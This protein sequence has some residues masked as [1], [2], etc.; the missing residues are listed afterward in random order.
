MPPFLQLRRVSKRYGG[1]RALDG[2][3]FALSGGETHGLIGENGSG[4][5]TLIKI[6]SGAERPEPGAELLVVD[7]PAPFPTPAGAARLGVQVIPQDLALFPNLT[8]AENIA[9]PGDL[10]RPLLAPLP[11]RRSA[12]AAQNALD[13][14]G[15]ALPLSA[16]VED[17]PVAER[18]LVAICRAIAAEARL[19][20]MDEPTAA[21]TAD[22]VRRLVAIIATLKARGVAVL[23]VSHRLAEVRDVA[24]RITVLRDGRVTGRFAAGADVRA[25]SEALAGRHYDYE[26]PPAPPQD[27]APLLETRRL[28]RNGQF[29][30]VNLSIRPGEIVGLV[31]RLGAGRTELALALFGLN[32]PDGGEILWNGETVRLRTIRQAVRLGIGYV[33][34]D[35]LSLGLV[36]DQPVADNV[37][38]AV[39]RRL[40][41]RFG[42]IDDRDRREKVARWLSRL[43][44]RASADQPARALSGGNQQRVVLARWMAAAPRLVILDN[45]TV[46]VDIAAR[47]GLYRIVRD[48]AAEGVAILLISDE[49]AEALGQCHRVGVMAEG[50]LTRWFA[51]GRASE[52]E[53]QA[54]V[55]G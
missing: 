34:E 50:R 53:I 14:V 5:S 4:K 43:S 20:I 15:H 6:I 7:R 27:G 40:R 42:L 22:E 39:L 37:V 10:G 21:L 47:D 45:P 17:L 26:P 36:L 11:K 25:L 51:A 38:L 33:P 32:R 28:R 9:L 3:D 13:R 24:D 48:L 30:D 35:R 16:R 49:V 12:E 52:A 29:R 44:V 18:Q 46:G 19:V 8:V 31:G 54:A 1:I 55:H 23:F 41:R 2:V